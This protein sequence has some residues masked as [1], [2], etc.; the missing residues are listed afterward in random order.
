MYTLVEEQAA[1]GEESAQNEFNK[2]QCWLKHGSRLLQRCR[3]VRLVLLRHG[4]CCAGAAHVACLLDNTATCSR[5]AV[6]YPPD[7][8]IHLHPAQ[9]HSNKGCCR[10]CPPNRIGRIQADKNHILIRTHLFPK[11]WQKWKVVFD[12]CKTALRPG[13]RPGFCEDVKRMTSE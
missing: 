8:Q 1:E 4:W 13:N 6:I 3:S 10:I 2:M 9:L 5:C 12:V 11:R 7:D